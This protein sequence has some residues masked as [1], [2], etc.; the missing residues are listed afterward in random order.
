MVKFHTFDIG[1]RRHEAP[2]L[3]HISRDYHSRQLKIYEIIRESQ[4]MKQSLDY[5][6]AGTNSIFGKSF[7]S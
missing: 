1:M 7:V 2:K 6:L 5:G 4:Y 3:D